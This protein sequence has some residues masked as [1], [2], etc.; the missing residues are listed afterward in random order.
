M[1][2]GFNNDEGDVNSLNLVEIKEDRNW[3]ENAHLKEDKNWGKIVPLKNY[4][5]ILAAFI[6]LIIFAFLLFYE[7]EDVEEK[8]ALQQRQI[9][10]ER[11]KKENTHLRYN[12]GAS[13]FALAADSTSTGINAVSPPYRY[14]PPLF[15]F[16]F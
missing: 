8:K 14:P 11:N 10:R 2:T 13:S 6:G 4:L 12:F 3:G 9:E 16:T 1:N 5:I 15:F 7:I